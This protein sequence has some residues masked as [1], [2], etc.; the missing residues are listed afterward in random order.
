MTTLICKNGAVYSDTRITT[1]TLDGKVLGRRNATKCE[2][3]AFDVFTENAVYHVVKV[4]SAGVVKDIN[5][6]ISM[7]A[8]GWTG[9]FHSSRCF[10]LFC[11][12]ECGKVVLIE[13]DNKP[14]VISMGFAGTGPATNPVSKLAARISPVLGVVC[15]AM[16]DRG[17]GGDIEMHTATNYTK[18]GSCDNGLLKTIATLINA[19]VYL[20]IIAAVITLM[21][22][23]LL[24]R[25]FNQ[26]K[27]I[28]K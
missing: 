27:R 23:G 11:I 20:P 18:I 12:A 1:T 4:V 24:V 16:M 5:Y 9:E 8:G 15:A 10:T 26:L 28:K 3:V 6:A 14:K 25:R 17:T 13:E 21:P 7:I 22:F 19:T 2:T